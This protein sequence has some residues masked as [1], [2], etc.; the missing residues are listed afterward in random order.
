M[1]IS[2]RTGTFTIPKGSL[3]ESRWDL[4]LQAGDLGVLSIQNLSASPLL[5]A[6]AIKVLGFL[7]LGYHE[8]GGV[9]ALETLYAPGATTFPDGTVLGIEFAGGT[10]SKTRRFDV[11][12]QLVQEVS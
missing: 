11:L 12:I 1:G 9:T 2:A 5:A 4:A 8:D 10:V 6:G 7:Q 3:A